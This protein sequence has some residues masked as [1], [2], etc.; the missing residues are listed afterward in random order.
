MQA[1]RF[2]LARPCRISRLRILMQGEGEA[3]VHV[4]G[5]EGGTTAPFINRDLISP[6]RIRKSGKGVAMVDVPLSDPVVV[7]DP[8]FFVAIDD[9]SSGLMLLS[10]E[11]IKKPSC[12]AGSDAYYPQLIQNAD[13][14]W[15]WGKYGYAIDAFITYQS[16]ARPSLQNV[17]AD[18]RIPDSVAS[19]GSIA[20]YDINRDGYLDLMVG[21]KVF[22]NGGDGT[23]SDI[24]S[25]IG[26]AG[27]PATNIF[28]DVNNDGAIDVLFVGEKKTDGSV[29]HTLFVNDGEG[30][31]SRHPIRLD[32]IRNPTSTSIADLNNDG[33]LDL[34]VGQNGISG[35]DTLAGALFLND[36]NLGFLR[37]TSS[38]SFGRSSGSQWVDYDG[39]GYLDLY[40]ADLRYPHGVL[41]R[42]DGRGGLSAVEMGAVSRGTDA[43]GANMMAGCS[44]G[45]YDND[46]KLDLLLPGS[47][48]PARAAHEVLTMIVP[49]DEDRGAD[50]ARVNRDFSYEANR[51]G[52]VLGDLNNDGL[53]DVITTTACGCNSME[54]YEQVQDQGFRRR[55][56]DYGLFGIAGGI[57]AVLVDYDNDGRLDL[58]FM[59]HGRFRLYRNVTPTGRSNF[60]AIDLSKLAGDDRQIGTRVVVYSGDRRFTREISSGRGVSMQ[61]PMRLHFGLGDA[62]AV[63]SIV[64]YTPGG[65]VGAF[66]EAKINSITYLLP[67]NGAGALLSGS[68]QVDA[69]PNPF[70]SELRLAYQLPEEGLVTLEIYSLAGEKV[71]TVVE[72][73]EGAGSHVAVWKA[74]DGYGA[75]LPAGAYIYR[76]ESNGRQVQGRAV[77]TR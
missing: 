72:R 56:F 65:A 77:L 10:D 6:V 1:A 38:K 24:T 66:T 15:Q 48:V 43:R 51:A 63:D 42:N 29:D 36:G 50:I 3:R 7:D 39:D 76:L 64:L 46:G 25:S 60:I 40:V 49:N 19:N 34:F 62:T 57:D 54:V 52:G 70:T 5:G 35:A 2:N 71:A 68:L 18:S 59:E 14:S 28:M 44:W 21:G 30:K 47:I 8:Q 74:R 17:T 23:F 16:A 58:S 55:T 67:S 32:G 61:D 45:D 20:W 11:D 22:R 27:I 75:P 9:L 33:L 26:I 37:D 41:W 69:S 73:K 4:F 12:I 53:L 31:F 13:R